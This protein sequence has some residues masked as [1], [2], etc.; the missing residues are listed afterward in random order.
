MEQQNIPEINKKYEHLVDSCVPHRF[1]HCLR[2]LDLLVKT[3]SE[4]PGAICSVMIDT[5]R[6]SLTFSPC[7]TVRFGIKKAALKQRNDTYPVHAWLIHALWVLLKFEF[8]TVNPRTFNVSRQ[9]RHVGDPG[10]GSL[11]GWGW[12]IEARWRLGALGGER[13]N[14][15]NIRTWVLKWIKV[16]FITQAILWGLLSKVPYSSLSSYILSMVGPWWDSSP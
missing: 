11:I 13:T 5:T 2:P 1:P 16:G 15:L 10:H 12:G 3:I 7:I 9:M 6:C 14:I 8:F 4:R